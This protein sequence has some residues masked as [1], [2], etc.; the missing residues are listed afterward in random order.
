MS[1]R[2]GLG[3]QRERGREP[4]GGEREVCVGGGGRREESVCAERG[5]GQCCVTLVTPDADFLCSLLTSVDFMPVGNSSNSF[6]YPTTII[7]LLQ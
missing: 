7:Y 1:V 2:C 4:L 5:G 6:T 3:R